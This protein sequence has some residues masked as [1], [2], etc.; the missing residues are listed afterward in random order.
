MGL[1]DMSIMRSLPN[2]KVM[3][4]ATPIQLFLTSNIISSS[5]NVSIVPNTN[6]HCNSSLH[7]SKLYPGPEPLPVYLSISINFIFLLGCTNFR[8]IAWINEKFWTFCKRC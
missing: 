8:W 1:E 6:G 2:M 3:Q 4:P 5:K 7:C